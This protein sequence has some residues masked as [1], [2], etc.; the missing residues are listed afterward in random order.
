M[1]QH[2][3]RWQPVSMP[4]GVSNCMYMDISGNIQTKII[5]VTTKVNVICSFL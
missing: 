2:I 5:H 3:R 1:V 4:H